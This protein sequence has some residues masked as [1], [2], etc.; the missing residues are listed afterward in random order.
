MKKALIVI[1]S[2]VA[3]FSISTNCFAITGDNSS[4][5]MIILGTKADDATMT[6]TKASM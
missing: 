1:L 3:L 6:P 4:S 5:E 2:I